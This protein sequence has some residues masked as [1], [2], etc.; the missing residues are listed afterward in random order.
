[1]SESALSTTNAAMPIV[2]VA[3][4]TATEGEDGDRGGRVTE[5]ALPAQLPLREIIPAV[6]RIVAPSDE[7][8]GSAE[9]LSLAPIGGA[10]YSLD[11]TLTTVG[12]VDGDLLALQPVPA[13]PPAPRIVEDIADAAMIFS[14]ARERPW[15]TT[16]IQRGATLA[17]IG[18][19]L[20]ATAL[21]VAHRLV[22]DSI[23]GVFAVSGV[24]IAAV[25][26]ALLARSG[27]PRVATA[28][29]A[30]ALPSVAAAFALAVPGDFGAPSVLLG[31]AGVAAWS[32]ISITVAERAIALF[33][34]AAAAALGVLP[35]AAAAT[36]WTLDLTSIGCVLILVALVITVQ[37]AQFSAM[38]ARLPVPVI[39][40]PGDPTPSAPS[41][42][43]LED[44]PRRIRAADS[45]Q[46]GFIAAGVLLAVTGS[47]LVL[48]PVL[49]GDGGVSPWAW[50]LVAATAAAAALRARVWDSAACKAWLLGH[51]GLL[52]VVLLGL[53][54][55]NGR[56][57]SAWWALG[58]LAVLTAAWA[59]VALNPR[60]GQ[61]E[62][63]SL[64]M[65][66][67][68]GF[69][70]SALDASVIPVMAYLVGVFAWVLNGF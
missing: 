43:V 26:G 70:G 67:I 40:A 34:T 21:A 51:S 17:V 45:H 41:L 52:T 13:G 62:T 65:R 14:A 57:T 10:P 38:C 15:G 56:Y 27:S 5:V 29:A 31:A 19:I 61:P 8:P 11:A 37:A 1:M 12:V 2:R 33:T 16:H 9:L 63:Y 55:A 22:T 28:L 36:L 32:I 46:S 60:I 35:A 18:L 23:V 50:Y 7:T 24:A 54:A 64:P 66:R 42:R 6:Q 4:L 58:A 69:V 44:L 47:V 25:L 48:W 39:P 20:V 30:A 49:T 68:V 59:V 53:F 3:V